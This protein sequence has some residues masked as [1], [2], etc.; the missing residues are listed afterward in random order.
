M[1]QVKWM[2]MGLWKVMSATD[3]WREGKDFHKQREPCGQ[4]QRDRNGLGLP[5]SW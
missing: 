3:E 2:D 4:K 1:E 5:D